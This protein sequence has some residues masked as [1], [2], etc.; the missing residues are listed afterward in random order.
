MYIP[1]YTCTYIT[2]I[3]YIYTHTVLITCRKDSSMYF[4]ITMFLAVNLWSPW[5]FYP[6]ICFQVSFTGEQVCYATPLETRLHHWRQ[7]GRWPY[8]PLCPCSSWL[9]TKYL[10]KEWMNRGR[11]DINQ[12]MRNLTIM[13]SKYKYT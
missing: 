8:S 7:G 4:S 13:E 1:V 11:K 12:T 3:Y 10:V 2:Y 6:R 5:I 9:S